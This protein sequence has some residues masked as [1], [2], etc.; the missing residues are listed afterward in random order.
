M[1][2]QR[3]PHARDLWNIVRLVMMEVQDWI[4]YC[5]P[6]RPFPS[7]HWSPSNAWALHWQC[8][9]VEDRRLPLFWHLLVP[10]MEADA[11]AWV[12][13]SDRPGL[14]F[15]FACASAH[16]QNAALGALR[17][18]P[19]TESSVQGCDAPVQAC[20]CTIYQLM[21]LNHA[22]GRPGE[23]PTSASRV[24]RVPG[25]GQMPASGFAYGWP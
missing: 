24:A 2:M 6:C 17:E 16:S 23:G 10:D 8:D 25:V 12:G 13:S 15:S 14:A 19:I 11:V 22:F 9:P 5:A 20:M 18:K 4:C 21:H 7:L 1:M 3:G